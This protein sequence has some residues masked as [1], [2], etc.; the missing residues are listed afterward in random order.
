MTDFETKKLDAAVL[1]F[2]HDHSENESTD[3]AFNGLALQIF[4]YQHR[5][6]ALYRRFCRMQG[7][8]PKNVLHWRQVPA[9]PAAGFKELVLT[10]FPKKNSIKI[11]RTSGTTSATGTSAD[12]LGLRGA[13]F[14]DTLRLYEAAIVP[15]FRRFLLKGTPGVDLRFL[16]SSPKDAPDSSLSFMMGV[17]RRKFAKGGGRFYIKEGRPLFR[18]LTVDLGQVKSKVVVLATAL[19]LKGFLDYLKRKKIS[20]RLPVGSRLMETGG[21]KGA[22]RSVSKAVLYA[23]CEKVLG[24]SKNDCV[25]EYGMTELSSQFYSEGP[26]GLFR[27][28]A[29]TRTLECKGLLRHFDLANRGSVM[30]VQTEDRGKMRSGGFELL[31]RAKGAELRGCSLSYEEFIRQ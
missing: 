12:A 22:L 10:T 3:E 17:V 20:L 23:E 28:P 15:P 6:N 31:G 26:K 9:M 11:F 1:K 2:I 16:I 13:H 4:A 27:G 14:F 19:A 24:I 21:F 29:W 18:E 8:G 25:S 7:K 30:A 5:R